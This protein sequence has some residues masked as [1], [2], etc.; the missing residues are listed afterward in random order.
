M[1]V[2]CKKK[3][4]VPEDFPIFWLL[5]YLMKVIPKRA[6]RTKLDI[7]A[8]IS[9]VG[10]LRTSILKMDYRFNIGQSLCI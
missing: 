3:E 7:Y 10:L 8:F 5:A 6:V 4:L 2:H 9:A 1:T